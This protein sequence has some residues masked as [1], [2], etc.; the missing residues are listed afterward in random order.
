[1]GTFTFTVRD[2]SGAV[3]THTG[4]VK[5]GTA[6]APEAAA[7]SSAQEDEIA[8]QSR[9]GLEIAAMWNS[10]GPSRARLLQR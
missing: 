7:P 3:T 8:M 5:V 4:K 9:E 2:A 1:M 10:S 6:P